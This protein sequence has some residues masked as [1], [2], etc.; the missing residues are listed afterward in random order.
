MKR[1]WMAALLLVC[2]AALLSGAALAEKYPF[3]VV[4]G[5]DGAN[6]REAPSVSGRIA[7]S[8]RPGEMLTVT[9][10]EDD[11]YI[12]RR[13]GKKCYV[14]VNKVIYLSDEVYDTV[15]VSMT[16]NA[17]YAAQHYMEYEQAYPIEMPVYTGKGGANFRDVMNM[18]AQP[19]RILHPDTEVYVYCLLLSGNQQW[20]V[21]EAD[22]SYGY[23]SADFL[24]WE[25]VSDELDWDEE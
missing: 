8:V 19:V 4:A 22:G 3:T 16:R 10:R 24:D 12:V 13:P 17:E 7:G 5:K 14:H 25:S 11:W 21:V 6:L 20:A 9:G 18:N 15:D 2:L 23:V 1:Q